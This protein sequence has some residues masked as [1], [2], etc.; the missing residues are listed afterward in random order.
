MAPLRALLSILALALILGVSG[1]QTEDPV[2]ADTVLWVR[3]NDSLS[4]FSKVLVQIVDHDDSNLVIHT[5]W[6]DRLPSPGT[7]I[8]GY[9]LKSLANRAFVVNVMAYLDGQLALYTQINYEGGKKSVQHKE[10]PALIA[11][12]WLTKLTP[13]VGNLVPPF[14]KDSLTYVLDIGK[15]A[16]VSF[17]MIT[18]SSH[19]ITSV[20]G[21]TVPPGSPSQPITVADR[22]TVPILV[23][24]LSTGTAT[25][26]RYNVIIVPAEAPAPALGTLEPSVSKIFPEFSPGNF[27]YTLV[28]PKG[29]DTVTFTITPSDPR[30]MTMT[31]GDKAILPG[32]RSQ[33]F[34][35]QQGANLPIPIEV[36]LGTNRAFYQVTVDLYREPTTP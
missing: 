35:V 7:D 1:C 29:V 4:K 15:N 31:M 21:A 33:V 9:P 24:D 3:L 27:I 12:D 8:Q 34:K 16:V 22:D 5:M 28:L 32:Q 30:T 26:R 2:E 18:A 10:V 13:S 19:A 25:T 36:F 17:S 6:N 20:D 23:T 14:H 11:R